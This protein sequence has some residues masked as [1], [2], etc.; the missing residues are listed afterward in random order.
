MMAEGSGDND[1]LL[2]ALVGGK[3]IVRGVNRP[4]VMAS[5]ETERAAVAFAEVRARINGVDAYLMTEGGGPV[6]SIARHRGRL[7]PKRAVYPL[8][9]AAVVVLI[10]ILI[11]G[12]GK[13]ES[14]PTDSISDSEMESVAHG[15]AV[16]D[17]GGYVAPDDPA[18][19]RIK[20]S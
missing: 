18:I 13:D 14:N 12:G 5:Y 4:E 16:L 6:R 1:D 3:W 11:L 7:D 8:G 19:E 10:L 2:V 15:L 9:A 20:L 17:E